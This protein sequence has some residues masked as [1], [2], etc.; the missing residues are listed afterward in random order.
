M[1]HRTGLLAF[2]FILAAAYAGNIRA[3][4]KLF[5]ES[6]KE[7]YS[8]GR[9]ISTLEDKENRFSINEA[10]SDSM[11]DKYVYYN[12]ET[13]NLRFSRSVFW[14]RF[15]VVDTSSYPSSGMNIFQGSRTWLLVKNEPILEDVRLYYRDL[16]AGRNKYIEIRAGNKI[17]VNDKV[18]KT[19][20]FIA[21]FPVHKNVPDTVYFRVQTNSQF[22]ISFNIMTNGE[23]VI[24][25]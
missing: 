22:I 8:L 6:G 10:A 13:L 23:Y 21:G 12:K 16:N 4:Q 11:K 1:I 7:D 5:V 20:D 3:Q 2:I 19:N 18:I 25:S 9:Y 15:V 24:N 14:F 17:P